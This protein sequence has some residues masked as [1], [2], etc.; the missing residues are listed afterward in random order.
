MRRHVWLSSLVLATFVNAAAAA[1]PAG[2]VRRLDEFGPVVKPEEAKQTYAAAIEKL[3]QT[4]GVLEVPP[5]VWKVLKPAVLQGSTR[6]PEPPGETKQ[7][8]DAPGVT[9]ISADQKQVILQVPPISGMRIERTLNLADRD[10][11]PH[12]STN[13]MLTLDSHLVYGS[14][15]YL[16]WL[17]EPVEKGNDRRFYLATVRGIRPGQFLNLHGG[18]GYGGGVVRGLVKDIG[19]DA[20]KQMHYFV[21]DT[22]LDHKVGAIMHNKNNTGILHM[23]QTSNND[24]QTYDVKVIRNQYAHGDTYMYYCDFNYMSNIHSAAGDEMGNCFAAFTR[25]LD[26]NFRGTVGAM[27]WDAQRLT[28]ASGSNVETLGDSRPLINLNPQ[29]QITA[30]KVFIISPDEEFQGK[31]YPSKL[32]KNARHGNTERYFG[33]VIRG[34]KDCPW[35]ADVVGKFFAVATKGEKTPKGNFRWYE[36]ASF[37]AN[38]DGTKDIEIRRF[39]WGAKNAGGPH[40]YR[41]ENYTWDNHERPLEYIIAP[42]TYVN[43]VSR[44]VTGGDRG[45]QKQIGLAPYRDRGSEVDFAKG[46][47]IEQAIGPDPVRPQIFRA[48]MWDDVPGPFPST[49]FDLYNHGAASRYSAMHVR[50]GQTTLEQVE[51][52]Y[53]QKPSWDNIIIVDTAVGVGIK[54]N[55][56][57]SDAAILFAQPNH[58]QPIKWNYQHVPDSDAKPKTATL[59]VS[60]E[61]G[62]LNFEG[63][64]VRANGSVNAVQGI[65]G[66]KTPAKNLRGKNVSVAATSDSMRIKFPQP[67]LDADYAVFIEQSWLSNRAI[68]DKTPDGFTI[69]FEKAAPERAT[70]DWMLVR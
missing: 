18:P 57:T 54:F 22:S 70:L 15:S 56:D 23:L 19:W 49:V 67:E 21:A 17:Q 37:K 39:W 68:S 28:F 16:D 1:E 38:D 31:R 35:T 20:E 45:G 5:D 48:W 6:I 8:R 47:A 52:N 3:R 55:A 40:L 7:W 26:N 29:K 34:D 50:S 27:D 2:V 41:K 25:S 36:I 4:G 33:G 62:E 60:K 59:T 13:P 44:A 69:T 30:G 46:D 64:G 12:W 10:S 63:G 14:N 9:V 42:G 51:T 53:E 66:D 43:D 11:L 61:T 32:I 65:S 58:E 24:N